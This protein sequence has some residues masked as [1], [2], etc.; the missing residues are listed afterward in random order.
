MPQDDYDDGRR[1]NS[2]H[3]DDNDDDDDDAD[4]ELGAVSS[5]S[6]AAGKQRTS[7]T[8]NAR[9]EDCPSPELLYGHQHRS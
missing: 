8:T 9:Q 1:K 6:P 4:S 2:D 7:G 5:R 3:N